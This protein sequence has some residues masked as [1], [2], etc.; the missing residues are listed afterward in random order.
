[1]A[2]FKPGQSGNPAGKPRGAVSERT[3]LLRDATP[4]LLRKT[5]ELA[6]TGDIRAI[7]VILDRTV[8]RLKTAAE[9]V[10][11]AGL[12]PDATLTQRANAVADSILAGRLDP[13]VGSQ[14]LTALAGVARIIETDEL[15]A[16]IAALE[17]R[18]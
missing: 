1:M 9:P 7:E 12:P 11:M 8:P 5:I 15:E 3:K 10:N 13:V 2:R 18:K 14:L 17:G 16:R 4:E 6:K